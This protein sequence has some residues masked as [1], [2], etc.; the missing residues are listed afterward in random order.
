MVCSLPSTPTADQHCRSGRETLFP[1]IESSFIV[2]A[3]NALYNKSVKYPPMTTVDVPQ[4]NRSTSDFINVSNDLPVPSIHTLRA[5]IFQHLRASENTS[6]KPV[7]RSVIHTSRR[8]RQRRCKLLSA[9]TSS[10]STV[11]RVT[12]D[13]PSERSV[14][15]DVSFFKNVFHSTRR[16]ANR[17]A[18]TCQRQSSL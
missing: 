15:T 8:L 6:P 4:S 14:S 11:I 18:R 10:F 13:E 1:M 3:S 7:C 5:Q 9:F 17:A 2:E 12:T 16:T